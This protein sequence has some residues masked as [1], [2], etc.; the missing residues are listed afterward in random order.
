VAHALGFNKWTTLTFDHQFIGNPGYNVDR[1]P[2]S[3]YSARFHA[4]F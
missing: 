4:E 3:V 1:G 2:V